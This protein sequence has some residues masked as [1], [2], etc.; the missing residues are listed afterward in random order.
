MKNGKPTDASEEYDD[1]K[2]LPS[3]EDLR[4]VAEDCEL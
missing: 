3:L 2:R 1:C 4:G